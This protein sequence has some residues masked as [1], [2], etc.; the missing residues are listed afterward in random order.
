MLELE[1]VR[2]E[3]I[4]R[5]IPVCELDPISRKEQAENMAG[6]LGS[7]ATELNIPERQAL[8]TGNIVAVERAKKVMANDKIRGMKLLPK[9]LREK[10]PPL[11][12][13]DGKG[14]RATV[15]VK[16]FLS[17]SSW[18]WYILE[19]EPVLDES[20]REVDFRFFGMVDGHEKELGY[21]CL[22]E[23]ESVKGPMGLPIE[24]DLWW[25]PK[26]LVEIAPEEFKQDSCGGVS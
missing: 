10:L 21:F 8:S 9:E 1:P 4:G 25:K 20:G 13:Q 23:L 17:S 12:A 24:R 7:V 16:F 26:T 18:T 6:F 5:P 3:V 22:S 11:Y 15:H 19:G 2:L 14:G